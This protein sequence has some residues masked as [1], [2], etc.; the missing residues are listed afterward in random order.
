[1][2]EY[3]KLFPNLK[4]DLFKFNEAIEELK[5]EKFKIKETIF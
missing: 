5:I 2:E 4:E 1:M 3:W